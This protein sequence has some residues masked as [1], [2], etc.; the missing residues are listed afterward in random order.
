[1]DAEPIRSKAIERRAKVSDHG[2]HALPSGTKS[3]DTEKA[4][5]GYCSS[6][7]IA[8]DAAVGWARNSS[9]RRSSATSPTPWHRAAAA[10]ESAVEC[11]QPR[12]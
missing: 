1:M 4:A 5:H 6:T 7:C 12:Q 3:N 8:W 10:N 9:T 2:S 11:S